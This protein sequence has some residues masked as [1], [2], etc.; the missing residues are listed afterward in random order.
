MKTD[1]IKNKSDKYIMNT[2]GRQPI[3]LDHG[4]K[5]KIYD[6][7]GNEYLDFFSGVAVNNLGQTP[8]EIVETIQ[9][10]SKK[11]IHSSN[12]YYNEPAAE[13]AEKLAQLTK[14]DKVFFSNS[15]AEA[16]EAAIKLARKY[17]KKENIIT[18]TN[19]FHGRTML[20]ITAS[21]QDKYK[22]PFKPLPPGF[23]HVPLNDINAIKET[24]DDNTAAIML[25][26]VQGEGGINVTSKE[27]IKEVQKICKENQILLIIDEVQTGI[28]RC[29]EILTS[30]IYNIK[31]DIVSIAKGLG[32]GFPIG[33]TLATEE[34]SKG[35]EPGDHGSTFG[36]NPLACAV[37]KTTLETIEDKKILENTKTTGQYLQDKLKELKEKYNFITE[38]RG[39][40]LL[41]GIELNFEGGEIVDKM[42]EKGILINCT[43]GK[44]L[45]F[46]P[47]L[48]ITKQ[49]I[50]IMIK[51]LD[52]IFANI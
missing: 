39:L 50:D 27:Y 7:D 1:E 44:V 23:K 17:T 14:L 11:M 36:G 6:T 16:N 43:A 5:Q 8:T 28:G 3:V 4:H 45:R 24:I 10:Q 49:D 30:Q 48:I 51:S 32:S 52:E 34:V 47:P 19:S 40:G 35:F 15:G 38:V 12:I 37:G 25:E 22:L 20:T 26:L 31:P 2:Y 33:A 9:K 13:L 42:R 21:G 18:A 41:Q 46:A 29:G